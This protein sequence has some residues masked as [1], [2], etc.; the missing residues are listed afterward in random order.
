MM[1]AG[2]SACS[3]REMGPAVAGPC[4][5]MRATVALPPPALLQTHEGDTRPLSPPQDSTGPGP[6]RQQRREAHEAAAWPLGAGDKDG[7]TELLVGA[8]GW[9]RLA[10][11]T[12]GVAGP[13]PDPTISMAT[14]RSMPQPPRGPPAGGRC[15]AWSWGAPGPPC[16]RFPA[17]AP[18][19]AGARPA[20]GGEGKT[21]LVSQAPLANCSWSSG[22]KANSLS[23]CK[24][25]A[26][27]WVV[28]DT[29]SHGP[30]R[31]GRSGICSPQHPDAA[32]RGP[33]P[34][35][36]TGNPDAGPGPPGAAVPL[37]EDDG[38]SLSPL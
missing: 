10:A 16:G 3:P 22:H 13:F 23:A 33:P 2:G 30:V 19:P 7:G 31:A 21:C 15:W 35:L 27:C 34:S 29:G 17:P 11:V 5:T 32:T 6:V 12:N 26:R 38:R 36:G 24:V 8:L 25:A 9:P 37:S 20:G 18:P 1:G 14:A 4:T 28:G